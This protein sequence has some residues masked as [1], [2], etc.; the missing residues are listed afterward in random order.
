MSGSAR[1]PFK[2]LDYYVEADAAIF[3]GRDQDIFEATSRLASRDIAIIYGPSGIGKTSLI[4]AGLFPH[5]RSLGWRCAYVRTLT[6]PFVDLVTSLNQELGLAIDETNIASKLQDFVVA[7]PLLIAFDQFEEFFIRFQNRSSLKDRFIDLVAE[8]ASWKG[9]DCRLLFS[10]RE[11]YLAKFDEFHRALPNI[12]DNSYRVGSLSAFGAREAIKRPLIHAN[13]SFQ[14]SLVT[15]LLDHLSKF[16]FDP[17][18]LQIICGEL[19]RNTGGGGSD[20]AKLSITREDFVALGGIE[21]I[22]ERYLDNAVGGLAV[23]TRLVARLVLDALISAEQTKR[24]MRI[25]DLRGQKFLAG[26]EELQTIMARLHS[27]RLLRRDRRGADDWFE[28]VHERL[29]PIIQRWIRVDP[30]YFAFVTA[31]DLV[32]F[33]A[34][35]QLVHSNPEALL[36]QGQIEDIVGPYRSR[37][38]FDRETIEF[39]LTSCLY[40]SSSAFNFWASRLGD[41]VTFEKLLE[42]A[43]SQSDGMRLG[44]MF[45][46]KNLE[47]RPP[48]EVLDQCVQAS[49]HDTDNRVQRMAG[50]AL[51]VQGDEIHFQM[52]RKALDSDDTRVRALE[53]YADLLGGGRRLPQTKALMK[54]RGRMLFNSRLYRKHQEL[55]INR[56]RIG[57]IYGIAAGVACSL[58]VTPLWL[59]TLN[60]VMTPAQGVFA[61]FAI[62]MTFT[63]PASC[64]LGALI[65]HSV[66]A[67]AARRDVLGRRESWPMDLLEARGLWVIILVWLAPLAVFSMVPKTKVSLLDFVVGGFGFSASFV[68]TLLISLAIAYECIGNTRRRLFVVWWGGLATAVIPAYLAIIST[69]FL[70]YDNT[71]FEVAIFITWLV[72]I[73]VTA[74]IGAIALSAAVFPRIQSPFNQT[75]S[76]NGSGAL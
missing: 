48:Q 7:A 30:D 9:S 57:A 14:N 8:I 62:I 23:D 33:S 11:D 21:G 73:I 5:V 10:L 12:L 65:G 26:A 70:F 63:F 74:T 71:M 35:A 15:D 76:S 13:I 36:N 53:V 6:D 42:A 17:A 27:Y 45:A 58:T 3:G 61:L 52:L 55:R 31:R 54:L 59:L 22:F 67:S 64:V 56:A 39:L 68:V 50:A 46:I 51:A 43:R 19:V 44:A 75:L 4:L 66:A 38:R 41:D 32:E 20:T 72:L 25:E 24:A 28:L 49:L 29:V 1:F 34:R 37:L 47:R 69:Y 18:F 16:D 40:R 60:L 2:L